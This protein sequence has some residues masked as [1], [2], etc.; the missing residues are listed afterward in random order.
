MIRIRVPATTANL[1]PG[2]DSLGMALG[3]YNYFSFEE[4]D[5]GL[6]ILGTEEKYSNK[7][8][9]IYRSML[10]TF[11]KIGYKP[12]GIRI[13]VEAEIPVSRG[14]GS[15]ASCIVGGIVGANKISRAGLTDEEVLDLAVEIEGHPDNIAPTIF[16]GLIVSMIEDEGII[17]NRLD[18][19]EKFKLLALIPDFTLSTSES[20]SVLPE[21]IDY[22][23]AVENVG[24]VAILLSALANGRLD[25]LKYGFKDNLHQPYRGK[26][27]KNYSAIKKEIEKLGSLGSYISGAGPTL[28]CLIENEDQAFKGKIASYLNSLDDKWD[29][30]ELKIDLNGYEIL[31][32]QE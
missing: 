3:L 17:Y 14:L 19:E 16:G 4:I 27:I 5:R 31:K 30:R 13:R 22:R 28:M 21:T 29:I 32:K 26:L 15:S 23:D 12:R 11:E 6:E 24:R 7:D 10:R 2:F 8:N 18:L 20:R 9:L 1:G 25:L